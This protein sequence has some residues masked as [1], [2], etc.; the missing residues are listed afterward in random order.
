[1]D[2]E[3]LKGHLDTILLAALRAGE[4]HGYAIIDTIR[5]GSGGTFD[6]P[7]GTIYPA[8]HRLE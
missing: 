3:M 1:M 4:A 6:L 8:L 7:E 2:A 5:A